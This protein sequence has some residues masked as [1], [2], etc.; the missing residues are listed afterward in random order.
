VRGVAESWMAGPAKNFR[1][2]LGPIWMS[3]KKTGISSFYVSY[4]S[5]E[6]KRKNP[7]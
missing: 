3:S 6:F 1:P 5:N 2:K 7:F 4:L